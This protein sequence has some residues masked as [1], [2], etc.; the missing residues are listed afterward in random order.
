MVKFE[1]R[2]SISGWDSAGFLLFSLGGREG[3]QSSVQRRAVQIPTIKDIYQV[4]QAVTFF[5]PNVGGHVFTL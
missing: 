1:P 5:I 2:L 4:I 3:N